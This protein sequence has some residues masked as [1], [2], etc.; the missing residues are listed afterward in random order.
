[1]PPVDFDS[2]SPNSYLSRA[3]QVYS[4]QQFSNLL[5]NSTVILNGI[6]YVQGN[7]NVPR[8]VDIT[9]NGVLVVD[10]NFNIGSNG[11]PFWKPNPNLHIYNQVGQPAGLLS[12]KSITFGAFMDDVDINGLIY[13]GNILRINS[14]FTPLT[15]NGGAIA[16]DFDI[17]SFWQSFV[18]N[19]DPNV[20]IITLGNPD[21]SP[22][23]VI[24][25]WEEEY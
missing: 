11:M 19:Y 22:V 18:I 4:Q 10:G 16:Y 13:A 7:V 6:T 23:I 24:E 25:H 21:T 5:N 15:I 14:L 2:A 12:K 3:D 17:S 8:G 20:I 9:I 1:M